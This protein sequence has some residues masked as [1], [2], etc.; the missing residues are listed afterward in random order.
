[1]PGCLSLKE[2]RPEYNQA[3]IDKLLEEFPHVLRNEPGNTSNAELVIKLTDEVPVQLA[4]YRIP[5]KL[6]ATITFLAFNS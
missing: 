1:M 4:P 3:D 5:G 2:V 6:K